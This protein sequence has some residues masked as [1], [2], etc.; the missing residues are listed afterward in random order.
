MGLGQVFLIMVHACQLVLKCRSKANRSPDT[1]EN[2]TQLGGNVKNMKQDWPL[3][4]DT[5]FIMGRLSFNKQVFRCLVWQGLICPLFYLY[6]E[7]HAQ[8]IVIFV[9]TLY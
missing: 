9:Y 1:F 2:L 6:F 5:I 8:N 4:H 7:V 3:R